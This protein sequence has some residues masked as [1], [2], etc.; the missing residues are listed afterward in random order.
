MCMRVSLSESFQD[1]VARVQQR[2]ALRGNSNL[3]HIA[4]ASVRDLVLVCRGVRG[5]LADLLVALLRKKYH[6][7]RYSAERRIHE[8][9][10]YIEAL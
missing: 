3:K 2:H 8:S 1:P 4:L 10:S 5:A 9:S 6:S 7:D